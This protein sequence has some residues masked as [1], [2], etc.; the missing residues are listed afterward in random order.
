MYLSTVLATVRVAVSSLSAGLEALDP[1]VEAERRIILSKLQ[2]RISSIM[3]AH[4]AHDQ[5]DKHDGQ[6]STTSISTSVEDSTSAAE[7]AEIETASNTLHMVKSDTSTQ[8]GDLVDESHDS[9]RALEDVFGSQPV[10]LPE[11][12]DATR[13]RLDDIDVDVWLNAT[14]ARRLPDTGTVSA[15]QQK[16]DDASRELQ[17]AMSSTSG[18]RLVVKLASELSRKQASL[19]NI[20]QLAAFQDKVR[21]ADDALSSL[22]DT[23]DQNPESQGSTGDTSYATSKRSSE[24]SALATS[25]LS[26]AD[27]ITTVRKAAVKVLHDKR[28]T[29]AVKRL[30][31][32]YA[33]LLALADDV[34]RRVPSPPSS[35]AS[36]EK[37]RY[38]KPGVDSSR[39]HGLKATFT[40]A[41]SSELSAPRVAR[42]SSAS[43][44]GSTVRPSNSTASKSRSSLRPET[45]TPR[46]RV[47]SE[48]PVSMK[49]GATVPRSFNFA[50]ATEDLKSR[51]GQKQMLPPPL[52]MSRSTSA[53]SEASTRLASDLGR[54]LDSSSTVARG[55]SSNLPAPT[56]RRRS[57]NSARTK[58]EEH[59]M[60]TPDDDDQH[61]GT[62]EAD[63]SR[64]V[65][66]QIGK[67]V[68]ELDL[69]VP[70]HPAEGSWNDESGM[71]WIGDAAT[72]RLY[73]CRILRSIVM[74]RVGGGWLNLVT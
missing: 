29:S 50:T 5:P 69:H 46:R 17:S 71:Y 62:Y 1:A 35:S 42:S 10:P 11:H 4:D 52:P 65:D 8:V 59:R 38:S 15:L 28:V 14:A 19:T 47:I 37:S 55:F 72:G 58:G 12:V 30:E 73:F 54:S 31:D 25:L 51:S 64:R 68:N 2:D 27:K 6:A 34:D 33:E 18:S 40:N 63:P 16:L 74:V 36:Y 61:P 60:F 45:D 7:S 66:V 20:A 24:R 21:Q 70:I 57:S 41:S 3:T 26:A 67:I 48:G 56:P 32:S 44:S 13:A 39:V 23:I 49:R 22:L 9:P 53:G 43:I